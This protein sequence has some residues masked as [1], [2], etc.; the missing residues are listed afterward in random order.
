MLGNKKIVGVCLTKIHDATR[1][2]YVNRLHHLAQQRDIKLIF[3][4]SFVDF[5]NNDVF[6]EGA[7]SVYSLINHELLD[8]LVVV[9]DS[10]INKDI[11]DGI[12]RKAKLNGVPVVL[13]NGEGE[14]CWSIRSDYSEAFKSVLRHVISEHGVTDT[15]FIAGNRD[16]DPDSVARIRCY[17]EVMEEQGLPFSEANIG[18][19][20]YW[21]DPA[22]LIT[23]SLIHDREKLPQAI[24]CANDYMAF[25]VCKELALHGYSVPEDVIV[26]GFD[27][28]PEADHFVPHLTTCSEDLEA[29]AALTLK[30][31]ALAADKSSSPEILHY[32]FIP[33]ISESCGCRKLSQEDFRDIASD[34]YHTIHEMEVH[35]DFE[36]DW[37]DRMLDI[38][39]M[40]DLS[41]TLSG[42][43]LENSYVCLN[44]DFVSSAMELSRDK[45]NTNLF[46]EEMML[47][48]SKYSSENIRRE[49]KI[50]LRAMIPDF[51]GW[52]T[53]DTSYVLSSIYVGSR[54]CGY[55]AVRT[56]NILYYKHKMK[57]VLKTINIAFNVAL[58]H[59]SQ[60]KLRQSVERAALTN[61]VTGLPNLKGA[62]KW[63]EEFSSYPDNKTKSL[64]FSVYALPKYN[65]ILEN[66]GLE[67]AEE[68]VRFAA[69][70]LKLANNT[71]CYIA[72]FAED[73]FVVV[74]IYDDPN[75]IGDV[76]HK[77]TTTFFGVIEG[78]NS[79][80]GKE[81]FVEVNC[82]CTVVNPGWEGSMEGFIK[83]ANG[84][85]YMNR[86]KNGTGAAVKE[87][88]APKE[89]YKA[90][91]LLVEKNLFNY[92]F[93]PIVS[94]KTGEIY[95]YEALMRTDP[96]IG[97]NPLEVLST[98]KEYRRL[99]EIE[100]ATL[101]N[102]MDRYSRDKD[103]FSSRKVFINTIPGHFLVDDDINELTEKYGDLM[104]AFVYELTEQDAVA[105]DELNA[106]R[107]LCGKGGAS[108]IAIDDYGTGHSNIV[109]LMRYAPQIIKIDRFL[110]TDIHKNQNKQMFVRST[111]EFARLNGIKVLAEGVET[112]NELRMVIDL[113]VDLIQGYYTARPA[114]EPIPAIPED[115]RREIQDANP[116]Y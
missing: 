58:T 68:A 16:N 76:I 47:I 32:T 41:A 62:V 15:F 13:V 17:K 70:S 14:D 30:A 89:H 5:F 51:E 26:T 69:E 95:G 4:N 72:Q 52:L 50:Q 59:F 79:T 100:R 84:E 7:R 1:S 49:A 57:R 111:I 77:A 38:S 31:A 23:Y 75:T 36:Y 2:D 113:G 35:E 33:H 105:D 66:Y 12:V 82:G 44:S 108:Q 106:I 46:S 114:P 83:F 110:I 90:F 37:I 71:E 87:N 29:L 43:M 39:D 24:F 11:A 67:A 115:I 103:S 45:E 96:S 91:E 55:Y 86:L 99:Y 93:Q 65:Y 20:G 8:A 64:S 56:D 61:I 28:V 85:M 97:M 6:D 80:S 34:L 78:Y 73:G 88:T 27:G 81:Y 112:S 53:D 54:V 42:C 98:A 18:Y 48:P 10:F 60:A 3:F 92:H 21:E 109:N 22:R 74:N 116:L 25:A 104:D 94:A 107:R 9:Y 40:N 19:G 102:V 63:F 101:F